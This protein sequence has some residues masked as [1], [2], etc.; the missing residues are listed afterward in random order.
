MA[1]PHATSGTVLD[2]RPLG[3]K[4]TTFSSIALIKT[5]QLE[6]VRLTMPRGKAMPAHQ[7]PGEITVQCLEGSIA[8]SIGGQVKTLRAGDMIFV[9][10]NAMHALE[11]LENASALITILL[12]KSAG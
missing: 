11:A 12:G 4:C 2:L 3:G 7:V 6:V 10:G 1:L 5:P 8:F 9:A